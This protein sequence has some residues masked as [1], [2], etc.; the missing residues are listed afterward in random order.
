MQLAQRSR[1]VIVLAVRCHHADTALTSAVKRLSCSWRLKAY[2]CFEAHSLTKNEEWR[3]PQGPAWLSLRRAWSW[4]RRPSGAV[5]VFRTDIP[6]V[7]Y[8]ASVWMYNANHWCGGPRPCFAVVTL[9]PI[10]SR[11]IHLLKGNK[12]TILTSQQKL[13]C[14]FF[15]VCDWYLRLRIPLSPL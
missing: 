15:V 1:N 3:T 9:N 5:M 7:R 10:E 8:F 11:T 6:D 13:Q 2:E 14:H 4:S 12:Q